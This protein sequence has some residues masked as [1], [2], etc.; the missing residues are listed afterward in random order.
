MMK[1]ND[2]YEF[3]ETFDASPYLAEENRGSEPWIYQLHG[4]LVHSGDL[5]A[6]HYYAFIKPTKDGWFYKYDDD[7][8]TKATMREVLEDNYGGEYRLPNGNA[9]FRTK[10][11]PV[12]RQNSAYMLVYIRQTRLDAVLLPV[13][14]DDTP[15][16]LRK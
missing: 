1:I 13:S 7:K 2:R 9:A 10:S 5:N 3:P 14:Q 4:V 15:P 8:V 12:L 6:G 11:K 16:H